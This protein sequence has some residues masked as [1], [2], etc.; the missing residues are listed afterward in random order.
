MSLAG[1]SFQGFHIATCPDGANGKL[2]GANGKPSGAD[3]QRR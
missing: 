2:S 3:G 1:L